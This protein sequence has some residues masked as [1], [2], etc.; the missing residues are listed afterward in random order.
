M[1]FTQLSGSAGAG[2]AGTGIV[3]R[4]VVVVDVLVVVATRRTLAQAGLAAMLVAATTTQAPSRTLAPLVAVEMLRTVKSPFSAG[5]LG[6]G[7]IT[8]CS[9]QLI[10]RVPSNCEDPAKVASVAPRTYNLGHKSPPRS[11]GSVCEVH[12]LNVRQLPVCREG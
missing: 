11:E 3:P 9:P 8:R 12:M 10:F 5:T 1:P 6:P 4:V 7:L 2:G